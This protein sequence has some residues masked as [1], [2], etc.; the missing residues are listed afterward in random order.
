MNNISFETIENFNQINRTFLSYPLPIIFLNIRSMRTNFNSF[1]TTINNIIE[2]I[3][4]IILVE[5]NINEEETS[6]YEIH[7]FESNFINRPNRSG[8]G[9]AIYV[10]NNLT[11]TNIS[12]TFSSF[13]SLCIKINTLENITIVAVYRP[14]SLNVYDF[15]RELDDILQTI[16]RQ[17]TV[18]L[19]GDINIDLLKQT[20]VT[21]SYLDVLANNG[22]K[23]LFKECTR[24]DLNL[25]SYTCI[26]HIFA[27]CKYLN[28][29][30]HTTIIKTKISDHFSILCCIGENTNTNTLQN[31]STQQTILCNNKVNHQIRETNWDELLHHTNPVHLFSALLKKFETIYDNSLITTRKKKKRIS[32]PWITETLIKDCETRDKLY[33]KWRNNKD[34]KLFEANYKKYRN[35]LNKKLS[36]AKNQYYKNKFFENRANMR[37]TWQLVNEIIGVKTNNIDETILRNFNVT[38]L[39]E[40]CDNFAQSFKQNVETK[41]H[42]CNIKTIEQSSSTLLNS[43]HI[44]DTYNEEIFN[45]LNSLNIKKS[46]GFD[47]IRAI[48]LKNNSIILTPVITKLINLIIGTSI[49][50][51]ILKISYVRPIYKNGIRSDFN[52]YRPI[53][54]LS[55][56][57]KIMEEIICRRLTNYSEKYNIINPKQ[58]GFQKGKNINKLLGN[59]ANHINTQLS[60]QN[61]CLTLFIDFTKAFDTLSHEKL[62]TTLEKLGIRGQCLKLFENYLNYRTFYIKI[63]ASLSV[64]TDLSHGVPQGSKLGPILYI[65]YT[66]ELIKSLTSCETFAYADD[67]AIVV[68]HRNLDE[69][70]KIMQNQLDIAARWCHDNGLVINAS[71]TKVMHIKPPHFRYEEV[72]LRFHN[73][74]CLHKTKI[75]DLD[76]AN[77]QCNTLIEIVNTY[78]YLGVYIDHNFKWSIHVNEV[79]KKLRKASYMMHQ[80]SYCSNDR[81][82]RQAYFSFVESHLRHGVTAWGNSTHCHK[83]QQIQNRI[84]KQLRPFKH[85]NQIQINNSHSGDTNVTENYPKDRNVLNVYNVYRTTL[86]N[87]FYGDTRFLQKISHNHQTRRNYEGKYRVEKFRNEYGRSTLA[88]MLP[89]IL[90]TIPQDVLAR[91]NNKKARIRI[92][93]QHFLN[94]Q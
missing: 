94:K 41:L 66:N 3:K 9:I 92:L 20:S 34:N 47:K 80:L 18:I 15:I 11:Y 86:A 64:E 22:M 5:T 26:D 51:N 52:N 61:H 69:A 93:K 58:Y 85:N 37:I 42:I 55:T 65:L 14:P 79:H 31:T 62:L 40:I 75:S 82:M 28:T 57:E 21:N 17:K 43:L 50:P 54:I 44:H 12:T 59:F 77:D 32:K 48:D 33:N 29:N 23:C 6:F 68:A 74:D 84:L 2:N 72:K 19:L 46:A 10:R 1:L 67:T 24:E 36:N 88:V 83:L 30:I 39:N 16:K 91:S 89:T 81:V 78:K 76:Y 38:N 90:N 35:H 87:E 7:G 49:I 73:T 71:K 56:I 4:I 13:E 63:G 70:A 45:I 53:A 27:R 8:G 60:K 25:N